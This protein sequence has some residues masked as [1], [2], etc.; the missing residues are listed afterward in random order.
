MPPSRPTRSARTTRAR[1]STN[2]GSS[3]PAPNGASRATSRASSA[4]APGTMSAPSIAR[5]T[6]LGSAAAA[7][8]RCVQEFVERVEPVRRQR[9]P[10]GHRMPAAGGQDAH[11]P[12]RQHRG[13]Q[14]EPRHRPAGPLRHPAGDPGDAGRPVEPLLDASGDDPDH[15]GMPAVAAHQQRGVALP[16]T[17]GPPPPSRRP[18]SR[19]RP[20]GAGG[21]PRPA[22]RPASPPPAD[23]R[24]AA[25][26]ARDRPG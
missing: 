20:P 9:E 12:R 17:A 18:A 8:R 24:S 3:L 6:A 7:A 1:C 2:S 15:A 10:R 21:S 22:W 26:A 23:R 5:S 14:I 25:A 19:P 13:A 11:L 16:R 4:V